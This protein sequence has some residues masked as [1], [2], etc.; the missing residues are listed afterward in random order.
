MQ[1]NLGPLITPSFIE[2]MN[3]MR[4]VS[5]RSRYIC[6]GLSLTTFTDRYVD[7]ISSVLDGAS[8]LKQLFYYR[9]IICDL[10]QEY[11]PQF[12]TL[13]RHAHFLMSLGN[14]FMQNVSSF[15]PYE[16]CFLRSNCFSVFSL[17]ELVK[18]LPITSKIY[19]QLSLPLLLEPLKICSL[20]IQN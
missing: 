16:V 20:I 17:T 3:L 12:P 6:P 18:E 13:I 19:V 2:Y 14:D 4:E 8:S 7:S 9:T 15:C 10:W 1:I 11:A 5:A